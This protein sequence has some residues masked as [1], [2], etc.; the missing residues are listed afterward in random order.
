[1]GFGDEETRRDPYLFQSLAHFCSLKI[2][3]IEAV[4]VPHG[5]L[6]SGRNLEAPG[7]LARWPA[8][9]FLWVH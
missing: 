4:F 1:M 9:R 2:E 6:V 7:G 3:Y 8:S 5:V